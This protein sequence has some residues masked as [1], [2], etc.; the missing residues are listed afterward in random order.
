MLTNRLF[1]VDWKRKKERVNVT[2][3]V[4]NCKGLRD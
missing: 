2:V 1:V 4:R 3:F